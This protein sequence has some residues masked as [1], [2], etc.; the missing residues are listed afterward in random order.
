MSLRQLTDSS[1][2]WSTRSACMAGRRDSLP[3]VHQAVR[4]RFSG[5]LLLP[6]LWRRHSCQD[7]P[8]D[9]R[10]VTA[11]AHGLPLDRLE[12]LYSR[13]LASHDEHRVRSRWTQR[14]QQ[15]FCLIG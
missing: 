11:A 8:H 9:T 13:A 1:L 3:V 12:V 7:H 6:P 2:I 5:P 10:R 4:R 15:G 14:K